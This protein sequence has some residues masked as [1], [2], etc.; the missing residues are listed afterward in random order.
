LYW[1]WRRFTPSLLAG[2]LAAA[3][4]RCHAPVLLSSYLSLELHGKILPNQGILIVRSSI[5]NARQAHTRD[6]AHPKVTFFL[7]SSNLLLM[8]REQWPEEGDKRNGR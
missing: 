2:N 8:Q 3:Q 4:F 5:L 7:P 1:I 6:D